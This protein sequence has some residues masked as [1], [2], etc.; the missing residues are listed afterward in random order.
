[1]IARSSDSPAWPVRSCIGLAVG[2]GKDRHYS[3]RSATLFLRNDRRVSRIPAL[4]RRVVR[5]RTFCRATAESA[6]PGQSREVRI[7]SL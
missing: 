2:T 5:A 4:I 7:A 3:L 6:V 1:M